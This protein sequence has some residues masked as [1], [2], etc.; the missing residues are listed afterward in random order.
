MYIWTYTY[1]PIYIY[2]YVR[3]H[4]S[5]YL[6]KYKCI[7]LYVYVS[8]YLWLYISIYIHIYTCIHISTNLYFFSFM[9]VHIYIYVYT[10]TCICIHMNSYVYL[11]STIC[12]LTYQC[13]CRF[14]SFHEKNKRM[15]Q[16]TKFR[17]HLR[18]LP[19]PCQK[20]RERSGECRRSRARAQ[21]R[22]LRMT[23]SIKNT[24]YLCT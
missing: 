6:Y 18:R 24:V 2:I 23:R 3:I 12:R 7:Y 14:L 16:Q 19:E 9:Y 15:Q 8:L 22:N 1:I 11:R 21:H 17:A 4:R 10:Y 13:S 5:I 20:P